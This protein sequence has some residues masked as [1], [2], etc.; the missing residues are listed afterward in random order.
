MIPKHITGANIKEAIR[1][2]MRDGVPPGRRRRG[3]CLPTNGEHLPPKYT[4]GL[5]HQVATGELLP[6]DRF[7]GRLS[8]QRVFHYFR[9]M[10][11]FFIWRSNS[12]D[13]VHGP[14]L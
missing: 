13:W 2:I 7:D 10:F 3:Y 14:N 8:V 11:A 12:L 6:S 9:R 1:L 5:A 4:I